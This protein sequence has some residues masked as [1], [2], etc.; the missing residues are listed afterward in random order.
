MLFPRAAGNLVGDELVGR[1]GIWNAQQRLGEAHQDHAL[2]GREPVFLHE[3][4]DARV[5]LLVGASG[6]D[7]MPGDLCGA[8]ALIFGEQRPFDQ[9]A[10]EPVLV[11]EVMGGNL[12]EWRQA[13]G[14]CHGFA[15]QS[16]DHA[17]VLE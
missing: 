14:S 15:P 4:V 8:A 17:H 2:F 11:H 13:L 6:V 7:Q 5:M 1:L 12:I 3:G 16:R 10:D 9:R